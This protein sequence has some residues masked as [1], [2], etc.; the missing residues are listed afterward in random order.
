MTLELHHV[1]YVVDDLAESARYWESCLGARMETSPTPV[2]AHGVLV[3][4]LKVGDARI[5]LVQ[6]A[7]ADAATGQHSRK[8]GMP[9]HLGFLCSDF[10]QR[11]ER[12]RSD[13]GI[14][15]RPPVPSEA[16]DGRRMCFVYYAN[17]GLV[18]LIER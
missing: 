10:D 18:E 12:V 15:V 4:F 5:E 2:T 3:A 1:A 17:V 16:F 13:G 11:V 8:A 7:Q 6:P 14:V 9:D